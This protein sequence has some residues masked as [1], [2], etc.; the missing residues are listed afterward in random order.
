MERSRVLGDIEADDAGLFVGDCG[1]APGHV[2]IGVSARRH[3]GH[4]HQRPTSLVVHERPQEL[5]GSLL[6]SEHKAST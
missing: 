5:L 6:E 3:F 4:I 2:A 1:D